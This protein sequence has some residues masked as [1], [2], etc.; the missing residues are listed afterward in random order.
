MPG[1]WELGWALA[2]GLREWDKDEKR[3]DGEA[4]QKPTAAPDRG[5]L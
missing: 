5:G 4:E 1:S 2:L 3:G